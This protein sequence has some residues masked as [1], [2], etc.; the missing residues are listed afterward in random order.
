[1]SITSADSSFSLPRHAP[2][3]GEPAW[4]IA[5]LFPAQGTWSEA[6]YLALDTNR[7]VEL[8]DGCL[9]V[10][11]MPT[12]FHQLL[13]KFLHARL[14]AFVT[15]HKLG[16]ALFAPLQ[17]RLGSGRFREPDVI[18]LKTARVPADRRQP[19]GADL[20]MEVVSEGE[21]SRERDFTTKRGEYALAGIPE[22]W[23][24]D[25]E[26]RQITVLSLD[27][28]AYREHGVFG[29]GTDAPSALL[30]GFSVNVDEVFAA[31]DTATG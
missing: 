9:E 19:E 5:H 7:L 31:G 29:A 13:V 25:P 12:V 1:M 21:R 23:I 6:D 22:Y 18:F 26:L 30:P 17:V 20:V 8:C 2:L 28:D 27:A 10:L 24:V 16:L 3:P 14:E 11:P 15:A 4:E